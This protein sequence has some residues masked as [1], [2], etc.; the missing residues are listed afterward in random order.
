MKRRH[1]LQAGAL[2]V[3][4]VGLAASIVVENTISDALD[5]LMKFS[6]PHAGASDRFVVVRKTDLEALSAA[7]TAA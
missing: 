3:T 4:P 1:F 7:V 6:T 2:S 5:Q